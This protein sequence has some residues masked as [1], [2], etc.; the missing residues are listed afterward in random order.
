[1]MKGSWTRK[2][3]TSSWTCYSTSLQ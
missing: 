1:M 3:K 2:K